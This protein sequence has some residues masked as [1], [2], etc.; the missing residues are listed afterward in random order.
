MKAQYKHNKLAILCGVA[1]ASLTCNLVAQTNAPAATDG[2]A[3]ESTRGDK[4]GKRGGNKIL[5]ALDLTDEQKAK[6]APILE[7]AKSDAKAI[8][9]NDSLAKKQKHEQMEALRQTTNTQLQ[10]VLTAE[11]FQKFQQIRAEHKGAR[12]KGTTP[13]VPTT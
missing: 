3:S 4:A 8:K 6:V 13:S 7:K 2:K 12:G 9:G 10:A 1:L 11:Q 5:K